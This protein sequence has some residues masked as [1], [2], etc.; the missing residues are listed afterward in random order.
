MIPV[1][2]AMVLVGVALLSS[3]VGVLIG[4]YSERRRLVHDLTDEAQ[5]WL[6]HRASS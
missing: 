6:D 3:A 4:A 2:E 1:G 5:V